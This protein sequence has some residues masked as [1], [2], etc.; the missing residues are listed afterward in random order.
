MTYALR[1]IVLL[2]LV[3]LYGLN[4]INGD[5]RCYRY[6][7]KSRFGNTRTFPD[8]SIGNLLT[9][10]EMLQSMSYGKPEWIPI[11][12]DNICTGQMNAAWPPKQSPNPTPTP[13]PPKPSP[14]PTP[15]PPKPSPTPTPAPP[16]PSPGTPEKTVYY[17]GYLVQYRTPGGIVITVPEIN[18]IARNEKALNDSINMAIRQLRDYWGVNI[19]RN[20]TKFNNYVRY[21]RVTVSTAVY[22]VTSQTNDY[23]TF[24]KK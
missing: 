9:Y 6:H 12:Y 18:T 8:P 10:N 15:A 16:K 19:S 1:Q 14:T 2:M 5:D 20:S 11:S 21:E 22:R 23:I 4:S 3:L 24:V 13:A 7:A 17:T